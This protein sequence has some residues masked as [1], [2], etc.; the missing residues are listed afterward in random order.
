M[1]FQSTN[2]HLLSQRITVYN[3]GFGL[4]KEVRQVQG[5]KDVTDIRFLDISPEIEVD[6]IL[7]EGL[8]VLE[9][10]YTS[11]LVS[12]EKI[13][14]K[15]ID[16]IIFMKNEKNNEKIEIRLLSG[17]DPIIAER[18]DTG[19]VIIDPSG[20]LTLPLL[21]KG[22]LTK[23]AL[24]CKIAEMKSDSEVGISYLTQGLEWRANYIVKISNSTFNLFGWFQITNN[25]GMSFFESQFKLAAGK[26][27]RY[28]DGSAL[29][30][31]SKLFSIAGE[32]DSSFQKHRVADSHV[33]SMNH[34]VTI[35]NNQIKQISFLTIEEVVFRRLYKVDAH[36]HQAKIVV[37]FDN[38][39]ANKLG[40]PLP[41]GIVKV[42]E[43]D[44][45]DEMMFVGEDAIQNTA[46]GQKVC[47]SIGKAFDIISESW[48]KKRERSDH[49]DCITYIY[50]VHN[51]KSEHIRV[52]V[53]HEVFEQIWEMESS[54]HDYELK[55]SNELEFRVHISAGKKVELEFTYKVDRRII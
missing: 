30:M 52:D 8:Y 42:Y 55:Q 35:L 54:S 34:P 37:E 36:S 25:S 40:I 1:E 18:I 27:N 2:Q 26:V 39:E 6:S 24:V 10:S 17:N 16:K 7:I 21:P 4:V 15:Y 50:K 28:I 53:K 13:L 33:Y 31:H 22:L 45:G 14:E 29:Q 46:I 43:Q 48:E 51:Q 38:I 32:P 12:K 9:Q 3:D 19:E 41:L 49:F 20:Q 23:P 44:M 5:K 11:N 47:L